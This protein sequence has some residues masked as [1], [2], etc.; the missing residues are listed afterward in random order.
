[1]NSAYYINEREDQHCAE[2][3]PFNLVSLGRHQMW[4]KSSTKT[5]HLVKPSRN[6]RCFRYLDCFRKG[7][8]IAYRRMADVAENVYLLKS[9]KRPQNSVLRVGHRQASSCRPRIQIVGERCG[10]GDPFTKAVSISSQFDRITQTRMPEG[11]NLAAHDGF[12]PDRTGL[13]KT[14]SSWLPANERNK[15]HPGFMVSWTKV[16]ERPLS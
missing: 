7:L 14:P 6:Q 2:I 5:Q 8:R 9:V 16:K 1:M 4:D 12:R 15:D 10:N 11:F 13:R 3:F